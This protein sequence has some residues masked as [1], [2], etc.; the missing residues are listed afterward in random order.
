MSDYG[1]T[2]L[3]RGV[4]RTLLG[5]EAI[6]CSN[7]DETLLELVKQ[8]LV[9]CS[10]GY[11]ALLISGD[12]TPSECTLLL[13]EYVAYVISQSGYVEDEDI[14]RTFLCPLLV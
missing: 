2:D 7:T 10:D 13:E 11:P 9:L 6:S 1:S 12:V 8:S 5:E 14:L 3:I 4:F